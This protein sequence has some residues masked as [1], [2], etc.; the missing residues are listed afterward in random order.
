M[1]ETDNVRDMEKKVKSQGGGFLC[2]SISS[3]SASESNNESMSSYCMAGQMIARA[4]SPQIIGYW[5]QLMPPDLSHELTEQDTN[6]I[7]ESLGFLEQLNAAHDAGA[8]VKE[9]PQQ[10]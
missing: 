7:T 3:T 9:K 6:E 5:V 4:P 10:P 8:T 1:A 2:F